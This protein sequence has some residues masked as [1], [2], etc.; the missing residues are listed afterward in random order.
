[1]ATDI[2]LLSSYDYYLP[3]HLI[4]SAPTLPKEDAKL[5]VYEREKDV[6]RHLKFKNLQEILPECAIIL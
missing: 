5:L 6:I 2:D 3:S 1:M 4:A